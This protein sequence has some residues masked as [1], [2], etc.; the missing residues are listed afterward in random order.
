MTQRE[1]APWVKLQDRQSVL[2]S[3]SARTRHGPTSLM[4]RGDETESTR[5]QSMQVCILIHS[6]KQRQLVRLVLGAGLL[7]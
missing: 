7:W 1:A 2:A 5:A 3:R 6:A 4:Q